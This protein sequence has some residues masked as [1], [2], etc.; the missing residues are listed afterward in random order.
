MARIGQAEFGFPVVVGTVV[1]NLASGGISLSRR[2]RPGA[3]TGYATGSG[4]VIGSGS[5]LHTANS[6]SVAATGSTNRA[7]SG[8]ARGADSGGVYVSR[9][10]GRGRPLGAGES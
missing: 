4:G 8:F 3:G 10:G 1:R 6:C 9:T 5:A 2:T 7:V